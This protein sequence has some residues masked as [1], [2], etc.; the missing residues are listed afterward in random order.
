MGVFYRGRV[1]A[2]AS[3]ASRKRARSVECNAGRCATTAGLSR[4][5]T[6]LQH[7]SSSGV[8]PNSAVTS[9]SSVGRWLGG[10]GISGLADPALRNTDGR[11]H[12]HRCY[13][14]DGQRT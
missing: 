12:G 3:L 6:R 1:L 8:S 13:A 5:G 14:N 9:D 4:R 2:G 11:R 10:G 7:S